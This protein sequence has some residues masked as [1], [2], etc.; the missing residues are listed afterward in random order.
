[1]TVEELKKRV[2]EAAPTELPDLKEAAIALIHPI[3]PT[4]VHALAG[5]NLAVPEAA[6]D[7]VQLFIAGEEQADG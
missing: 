1:M 4:W 5:V 6:L 2:L 7:E 3:V